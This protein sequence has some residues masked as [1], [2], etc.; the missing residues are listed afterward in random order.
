M[1]NKNNKENQKH[2]KELTIPFENSLACDA[3]SCEQESYEQ[4]RP[5]IQDAVSRS[6]LAEYLALS[7]KI[8]H[9]LPINISKE[10]Q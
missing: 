10:C 3:C 1:H 5:P 6:T 2:A 7:E 9:S 4:S 8:L